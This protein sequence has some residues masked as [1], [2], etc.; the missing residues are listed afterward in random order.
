MSIRNIPEQ[1]YLQLKPKLWDIQ[2]ENSSEIE[3]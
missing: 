1:L 3:R 2:D